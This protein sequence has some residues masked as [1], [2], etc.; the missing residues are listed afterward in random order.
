MEVAKKQASIS[1]MIE[2]DCVIDAKIRWCL[3]GV[4]KKWS[5]RSCDEVVPLFAVMFPDSEVPGNM[6]LKKGKCSYVS[7]HA[8]APYFESVLLSEV[9]LS[10]YY[11]FSFDESLNKN[12]KRDR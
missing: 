5:Q 4:R 1:E 2:K 11:A 8:I 7:K 3:Y 6:T 12:C 9:A 10:P